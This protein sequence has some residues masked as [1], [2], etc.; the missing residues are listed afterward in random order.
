MR[1]KQSRKAIAVNLDNA[2]AGYP[3]YIGVVPSH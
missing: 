1:D 2:D 3:V